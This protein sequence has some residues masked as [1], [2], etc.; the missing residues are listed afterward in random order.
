M[1]LKRLY[2]NKGL[3]LCYTCKF[4]DEYMFN[5]N[6]DGKVPHGHDGMAFCGKYNDNNMI[7]SPLW[8]ACG[9]YEKCTENQADYIDIYD[10][11]TETII[12]NP[13]SVK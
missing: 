7:I 6:D 3:K 13:N 8:Y 2:Y 12:K 11:K 10:F 4:I 9:N 5:V 1:T